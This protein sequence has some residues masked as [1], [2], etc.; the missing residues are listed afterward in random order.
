MP[1]L[2]GSCEPP[3]EHANAG[4]LDPRLGAGDGRLEIFG[5][6]PTTVE[7][8]KRSF[9][10]PAFRLGLEGA[11]TLGPCDDLDCPLAE[12]G[13]R[14]KQLLPAVHPVSEDVTQFGKDEADI[15]QQRYR[16]VIVLDVGRVHLHGKQRAACIGDDV[17]FASFHSLARI[18]PA[19]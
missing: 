4:K 15:F 9:N 14:I 18:K 19:W 11:E 6:A 3:R 1:I 16:T 2:S 10:D 5:K 12:L 17:T 13:D 7:P 8:S